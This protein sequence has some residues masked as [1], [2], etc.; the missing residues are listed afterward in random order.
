MVPGLAAGLT[1]KPTDLMGHQRD[2]SP[3]GG[4]LLTSRTRPNG[5]P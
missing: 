1:H 4:A 3:A 5:R 2:L